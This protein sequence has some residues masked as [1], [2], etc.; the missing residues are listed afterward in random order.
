MH[1]A[2]AVAVAPA[3]HDH[4]AREDARPL[5][6]RPADRS[7]KLLGAVR[8]PIRKQNFSVRRKGVQHFGAKDAVLTV[9]CFQVVVVAKRVNGDVVGKGSAKEMPI[10]AKAGIENRDLDP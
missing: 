5:V 4:G 9:L 8:L 1:R 2:A 3:W 10:T 7:K 6:P